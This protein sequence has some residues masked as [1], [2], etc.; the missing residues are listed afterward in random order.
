M[1]P[2]SRRPTLVLLLSLAATPEAENHGAVLARARAASPQGGTLVLVDES[3]FLAHMQ[4]DATL[5]AR[6]SQ[7]RATWASFVA[8]HGFEACLVDL[9][10]LRGAADVP[11][12]PVERLRAVAR[13]RV[14]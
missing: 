2:V 1:V 6:I 12:A 11:P 10:A 14:R 13:D 5:A 7:R 4:G 9:Q 3:P 8:G